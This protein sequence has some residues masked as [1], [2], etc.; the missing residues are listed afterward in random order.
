MTLLSLAIEQFCRICCQRVTEGFREQSMTC[1]GCGCHGCQHTVRS[2]DDE[3]F[4]H[5]QFYC[6]EC[7]ELRRKAG[8]I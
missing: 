8:K 2:Y 1:D 7:A 4:K 6:T 3:D 5:E